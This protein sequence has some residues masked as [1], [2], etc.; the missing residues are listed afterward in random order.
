V[1]LPLRGR[2]A[3]WYGGLL[4][5]ILLVAGTF[6][7]ARLRSDLVRS[8][9]QTLSTR[10]AQIAVG[11]SHG[12]EGEFQ[13]VSGASL[14]GLPQGESGAQLLAPDGSVVETSGAR[15]AR[16]PLLDAQQVT[17]E[18]PGQSLRLTEPVGPDGEPFRVLAFKPTAGCDGTIVVTASLDDVDRS[19][20]RL[21]MLVLIACPV[22]LA[23]A[24]L[25]GWFVAGR[26]LRPVARMTEEART[27]GATNLTARVEVPRTNDELER[28]GRTLNEM[29]DRVRAGVED[30]RQF[31]ADASHEL[32]TPLAIMTS[33]LDVAL[34]RPDLDLGSRE[35][36]LSAREEVDRMRATVEDLLTLARLDEGGIGLVLEPTELIGIASRV[37]DVLEPLARERDVRLEVGGDPVEVSADRG[38]VS[39]VVSNLVGNALRY[40][41][42]GTEVEVVI[43]RSSVGARLSVSD[44]GPGIDPQALQHVFDRFFRADAARTGSDGGS[45]LGLAICRGIVVAHGG[46]IWAGSRL[47]GGSTFTF[48]LPRA[49]AGAVVRTTQRVGGAP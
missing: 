42:R 9:D 37:A 19:V 24:A 45:G 35:A 12:C 44:R 30:Q 6:L 10:A 7:V 26:A 29:L 43:N 8:L 3:L 13:D 28:L 27:I 17:A 16:S 34:D 49:T 4:A 11:L 2:L 18:A 46:R 39:R 1:T 41:P 20:H 48:E 14:A 40:A 15:V 36:L 38:L 5:L 47:R 33:E 21:L 22:A 25:G 32:R 23:A 31:I